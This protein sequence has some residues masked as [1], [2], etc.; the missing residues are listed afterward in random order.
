MNKKYLSA[1]AW[2]LLYIFTG[3]LADWLN[4]PGYELAIV[5]FP[6][7]VATSAFLRVKF[8]QWPFYLCAFTLSNI[9]FSDFYYGAITL[10]LLESLIS[11]PVS[12]VIAWGVRRF[13]RKNDD[14]YM[15]IV[16]LM[17]TL[18][19]SGLDSLLFATGISLAR[20]VSFGEIFWQ[21]FVSDVTG[22]I[23]SVT[24]IMAMINN[25]DRTRRFHLRTLLP[26][27]L[28]LMTIALTSILVFDRD[29]SQSFGH[30]LSIRPVIVL[31]TCIPVMLCA[32]T[33]VISGNQAGAL[34]LLILAT[35]SMFYTRD[36]QGPFFAE[37]LR[38]K[39]PLILLQIYLTGAAVLLVFAGILAR[40]SLRHGGDK[41]TRS[42][43]RLVYRLD[44][45]DNRL[46]WSLPECA[47]PFALRTEMASEEIL[48]DVHP[49][50]QAALSRHWCMQT[51]SPVANNVRFRFR[52]TTGDWVIIEDVRRMFLAGVSPI[53]LGE[54][55]VLPQ[56][57]QGT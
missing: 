19:A 14:L 32:V 18:L 27:L 30:I 55:V 2:I 17:I 28:L 25:N 1:S 23:F 38:A 35:V 36:G 4:P 48:C 41:E 57:G 3:L 46:T 53:V 56:N 12:M 24:V 52:T 40:L 21:G 50:D 15:V 20:S 31:L 13:S 54:W 9:F 34:S 10:S 7:G 6:S 11:L 26:A 43:S 16:G 42:L 45:K 44:L 22:I 5:W 33:I 8:R 47:L 37:G 49:N 39:E 29:V 51:P